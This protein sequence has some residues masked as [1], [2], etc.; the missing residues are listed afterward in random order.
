MKKSLQEELERIHGITYGNNV[1][2]EGFI[3]TILQKV[4]LKGGKSEKKDD[5]RKADLVSAD[6]AEFFKTLEDAAAS[7]G[8]TQ[9]SKGGFTFQKAVESMQIG[10]ILLGYELPKHGVDGLFGPET[11][12]AV[13]KFTTEKVGELKEDA[14]DLRSTL[15]SLGYDE[16]GAEISSGG[17]ITDE[18]SK[19]V[20]DIL[21]D[22]KQTNPNVQV[23]VTA[24]N[25]NFHKKVGYKSKH[26]EGKAIDLVLK[27]YNS[28]NA[29]S[30][31]NIL[32]KY[33][34]KDSKFSYI[35][36]YTNP[37][38]AATGGHFHLQYGEGTAK[39]SGNSQATPEMLNKLIELLKERGV[40]SEEIK[41][42]IDAVLTGGSAEF[43]DLDLNTN[44]G[45]D[46]YAEICQKFISANGP[47]PLGITGEMMAKGAKEAFMR[48]QR[49]VPPEL[50]L[51]QLVLEGGIRNGK[52]ESRPIRTKNP[53]NVGNTDSGANI[54]HSE[55]QSGINA[56]YNL[57]AKNYLG[58]G[59]T[60][61]DLIT[62]FV[63]KS[64]NRY[65]SAP[66]YEKHLN[67]LAA[68]AHRISA[69]VMA[70]LNVKKPSGSET[71]A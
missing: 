61:K 22:Y 3:D 1:I 11:A 66:D 62:N 65:A 18:I 43:T 29:K 16:K 60:A 56:Y 9:Q 26:T 48:Y 50:A 42:F 10:L 71:M 35:D 34:S 30:F 47:N 55:V 53:F 15:D 6:V 52:L 64:G 19:I 51:S 33:K 58:K 49:Y 32:N 25:D 36:E 17:N 40:K 41:V 70:K 2:N 54:E 4:G 63:N 8:L 39:G 13:R 46:A 59:R 7:G 45:F 67:T 38:G 27:P 20:S 12:Q 68:Q 23:I 21:K 24:G 31:M 37:S 5:P 14:S 28:E 69:P 44:E 57:V